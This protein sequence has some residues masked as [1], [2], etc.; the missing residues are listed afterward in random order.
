MAVKKQP[1]KKVLDISRP[2]KR[3]ASGEV[4]GAPQLVIP[5]RS[6]IPV[7]DG[8]EMPSFDQTVTK[9]E[10]AALEPPATDPSPQPKTASSS[11]PKEITAAPPPQPSTGTELKSPLTQTAPP[12]DTNDETDESTEIATSADADNEGKPSSGKTAPHVRKALDDAK[13]QDELQGYIDN[14]DF[15]VPI[16]AVARK[17]SLKV[18]LALT[19]LELVLGVLLL[20]LMLDAGLIQLLEKIP[21][22][23]FFNLQ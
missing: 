1:E 13:R 5:K 19:L 7:A 23:N 15:Y 3:P 12:A 4:P 2:K 10:A 14:R 11:D 8:T 17:R 22:T 18:S 16:N 21:H 6:V 9:R 20:N